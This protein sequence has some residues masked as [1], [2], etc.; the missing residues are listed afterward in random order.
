MVTIV[1]MLSG[2]SPIVTPYGK[3]V[4]AIA[5]RVQFTSSEGDHISLLKIYR[6]FTKS[7]NDKEFCSAHYLQ[8]R[9]LQFAQEIRKQ[10][11]GL[12]QKIKFLFNL[13]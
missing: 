11:I 9:N 5:S 1:S 2:D 7:N 12:C 8:R 10:L 6:A 4:E 13:V 3:R